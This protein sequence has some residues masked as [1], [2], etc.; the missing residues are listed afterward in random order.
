MWII[1][2]KQLK[3]NWNSHSNHP[4]QREGPQAINRLI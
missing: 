3:K 2:K 1:I 4:E